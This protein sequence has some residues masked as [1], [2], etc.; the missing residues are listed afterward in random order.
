[1]T[2]TR[3]DQYFMR[4]V[5]AF[6][7]AT[8][9]EVGTSILTYADLNRLTDRLAAQLA[10]QSSAGSRR[11]GL[12]ASRTI[13]AYA[14]YLAILKTGGTV[15]PLSPDNPSE[16]TRTI[17]QK[18]CL[19]AVLVDH[20]ASLPASVDSVIELSIAPYGGAK[21]VICE[22]PE[23]P[24][25]RSARIGPETTAYVIFTSGSTG[26]PKGVPI[27]HGNLCDF[28]DYFVERY[29][30]KRGTRISQAFE[31]CF[32]G[33]VF[34]LFACW[35][36]G[37]ALIVPG[38]YD[39]WNPVSF[40]N[41]RRLT[42]WSSVPSII[43]LAAMNDSLQPGAMP[44][45]RW[46]IFGGE[47]LPLKNA[48]LWAAAA[49][50]SNIDCIYGPTE[51]TIVVSAYRLPPD[52]ADWPVTANGTVPIGSPHPHMEFSIRD[53]NGQLAN[54]G[55]L[56][57]RGSQRFDGY[58]DRADNQGRF[59]RDENVSSKLSG[60]D[61]HIDVPQPGDWYRTGD[62]VA[63]EGGELIH[64]GRLDGQVKVRGHRVELHEIEAELKRLPYIRE[65]VVLLGPGENN[66]GELVA[67]YVGGDHDSGQLSDQLSSSLPPY[68]IP[69]RYIQLSYIPLNAS[70]KIDRRQL[71]IRYGR[72]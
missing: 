17:I 15:V 62:Y 21:L 57:V 68:M 28:L 50:N 56:L 34:E 42:H 23:G 60:E 9:L 31:L 13:T 32:D 1:M 37:G 64:R 3:L 58:L 38:K 44:G 51:T 8:A 2:V 54:A 55:E 40:I 11:I 35:A 24:Q 30:M 66:E 48:R 26:Y 45:L 39:V 20:N 71:A 52:P 12:L 41:E 53:E 61:A 7:D 18:A 65:A 5:Q 72:P 36:S 67:V 29:E 4:S 69:A 43:S 16:R 47:Q 25:L 22:G 14:G 33:S 70:G 27:R 6:P 59:Y 10:A 19:D 49:R 63:I 46:S